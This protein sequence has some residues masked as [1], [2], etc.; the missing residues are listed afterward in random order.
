MFAHRW[1]YEHYIGPIESGLVIDHLCRTP[2]CVNPYHL[3]P[4]T[5]AENLVRGVGPQVTR[6]RHANRTHCKRGHEFTL[7]NTR[8][9]KD[10]RYCA[11]CK[12]IATREQ[13][14]RERV[15]GIK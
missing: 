10:G 9:C 13:K 6:E 8:Y 11:E 1:S 3:E 14:R 12:R 7:E 5:S 15:A 4:V 2:T